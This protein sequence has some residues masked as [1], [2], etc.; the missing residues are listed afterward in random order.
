[1][2][3]APAVIFAFFLIAGAGYLAHDLRTGR[4]ATLLEA[5]R[6]DPADYVHARLN[7]EAPH[8]FDLNRKVT[9]AEADLN[10]ARARASELGMELPS[11]PPA[12]KWVIT[13][14]TFTTLWAIAFVVQ[15]ILDFRIA[16]AITG[17]TVGAALTSL[18]VSGLLSAI[19]LAAAMLWGKRSAVGHRQVILGFLG[20][21][22][23][24]CAVLS[25]IVTLAPKRAELDY[26]PRIDAAHQQLTMFDEDGDTTAASLTRTT[27][28]RLEKQRDQAKTFYQA[29]AVTAGVLEGGASLAVPSGYLLLS[30]Y[31][32]KGLAGRKARDLTKAQ[33]SVARCRERFTARISRTLE[34]AGVGQDRLGPLLSRNGAPPAGNSSA[35][36]PPQQ[37]PL[38]GRSAAPTPTQPNVTTTG[39]AP[40]RPMV[41]TPRTE[42]ADTRDPTAPDP[43]FDQA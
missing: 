13:I 5:V 9:L 42:P 25:V 26:A 11:D 28:T 24:M 18:V 27:I 43:T 35:Q 31:G 40:R 37:S 4:R 30:Y 10:E 34:I 36:I 7:E 12:R 29:A 2:F 1:M 16:K 15:F 23:L 33:H 8:Q 41:T 21:A 6:T 20:A 32:A 17:N 39:P 14:L 3:I 38:T 19:T 22:A